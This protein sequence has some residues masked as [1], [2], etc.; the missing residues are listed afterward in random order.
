MEDLC[1]VIRMDPKHAKAYKY[2]ALLHVK[3][4]EF[5]KAK[6]DLEFNRKLNNSDPEA[7]QWLGWLKKFLYGEAWWASR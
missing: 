3:Q 5:E 4:S 7:E 6:N 1:M 2:R